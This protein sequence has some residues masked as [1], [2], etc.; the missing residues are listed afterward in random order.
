MTLEHLS[1]RLPPSRPN[2]LYQL[3]DIADPCIQ[4]VLNT[5]VPL[6]TCCKVSGNKPHKKFKRINFF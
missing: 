2:Q 5:A 1:F 6:E 3:C 4:E